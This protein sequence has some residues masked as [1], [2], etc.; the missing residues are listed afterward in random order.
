[1]IKKDNFMYDEDLDRL[2]ISCKK[3]GDIIYGSVRVLNVT[4]DFTTNDKI[5][6][7]EIRNVSEYLSSLGLNASIL[8]D[9]EDAN[10]ISKQYR[11]GYL[12]YFLLKPAHGNIERVP[13]NVPMNKVLAT[14]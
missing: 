9:L 11:D 14:P 1:M 10:L 12:I 6:N 3:Q 5:V 13:F 4:L 2:M 8:S 7:V